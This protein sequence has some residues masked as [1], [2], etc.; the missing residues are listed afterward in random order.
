MMLAGVWQPTGV[1]CS[2]HVTRHPCCFATETVAC[3][4]A[5]NG[6]KSDS[7]LSLNITPCSGMFD[8]SVRGASG[9]IIPNV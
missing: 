5:L 6:R 1:A 3:V 2:A 7:I 4:P 8:T 9:V